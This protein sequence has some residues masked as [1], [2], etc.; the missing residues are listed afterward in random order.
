MIDAIGEIGSYPFKAVFNSF[1]YIVSYE[2]RGKTHARWR[3][4]N[5]LYILGEVVFCLAFTLV[6]LMLLVYLVM[7]L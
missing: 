7:G 6:T 3:D 2:F 5:L 1:R 4:E